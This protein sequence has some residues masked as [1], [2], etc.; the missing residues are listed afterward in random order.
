MARSRVPVWPARPPRQRCLAMQVWAW[1]HLAFSTDNTRNTANRLP[2]LQPFYLTVN[3]GSLEQVAL[4]VFF[5]AHKKP[6]MS[7]CFIE[8]TRLNPLPPIPHQFLFTRFHFLVGSP[9]FGIII[10]SKGSLPLLHFWCRCCSHCFKAKMPTSNLMLFVLVTW[11]WMATEFI[12]LVLYVFSVWLCVHIRWLAWPSC[13]T[14]L[15]WVRHCFP[16]HYPRSGQR[17]LQ[18]GN[19]TRRIA[20]WTFQDGHLVSFFSFI[21]FFF[22]VCFLSL[23]SHVVPLSTVSIWKTNS[24]SYL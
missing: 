12:N 10:I 21:F 6:T 20:C 14:T 17:S 5:P 11:C 8:T 22:L 2:K 4:C 9:F 19:V 3:T 1:C 7:F 24:I 18:G 15:A 13:N 23:L 16:S